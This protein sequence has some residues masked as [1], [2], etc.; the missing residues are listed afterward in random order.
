MVRSLALA[1]MLVVPPALAQEDEVIPYPD[2]ED[3]GLDRPRGRLPPRSDPTRG[4]P[5]ETLVEQQDRE[6]SLAGLDDPNLGVGFEAV[7][8]LMLL[9]SS[10]GN[11][12]DPRFAVGARFVWEFGR[13]FFAEA[14]RDG[15]FA[16]F[17][18]TYSAVRDGTTAIFNDTNYHYFMVAP[19]FGFPVGGPDFLLYGQLGAGLVLQHSTLRFDQ[20]RADTTTGFKPAL[21]YGIGFRGR[22]LL[23]PDGRLRI[24]FRVELTRFRRHYMDDT[25]FGATLGTAF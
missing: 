15:L 12:V 22:P 9:E 19:A 20:V 13:L 7:V 18:W 3:P 4:R 16:D 11:L 6:L 17:S 21:Q 5:E 8:G 14:L 2:E 24:A 10:R 1:L 23:S 25:Y